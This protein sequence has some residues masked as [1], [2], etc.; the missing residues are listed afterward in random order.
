M[1]G[2]SILILT[3]NEEINLPA[4]I[5]SCAWSDDIVEEPDSMSKDRTLQLAQWKEARA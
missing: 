5:D 1:S 3:L 2:V 4:C